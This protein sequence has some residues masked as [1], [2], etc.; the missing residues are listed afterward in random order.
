M[1]CVFLAGVGQY[2]AFVNFRFGLEIGVV[3]EEMR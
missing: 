2:P 1:Q 3:A